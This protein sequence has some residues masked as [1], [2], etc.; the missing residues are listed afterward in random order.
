MPLSDD[1]AIT[2]ADL[3]LAYARNGN[4]QAFRKLVERHVGLVTGVV[5]RQVGDAGA[6]EEAVQNVFSILA[7]KAGSA[8]ARPTLAGWLCRTAL[9]ESRRAQRRAA[10]SIR[11]LH[12][13]M[14]HSHSLTP[15]TPDPRWS[16]ALPFLDQA[17]AELSAADRDLLLL[18]FHER[19]SFQLIGDTLGKS[20]DASQKQSERALEKLGNL[21][22][23][24][25]ITLGVV[26]LAA[27]LGATLSAKPS[28]AQFNP[29][30]LATQAVSNAPS[31]GRLTLIHHTLETMNHPKTTT[32]IATLLLAV[33][34]L[35]LL[36]RE[37][38]S[39][40]E[41]LAAA[42]GRSPSLPSH[43]P[44]TTAGSRAGVSAPGL[45]SGLMQDTIAPIDWTQL[46]SDKDPVRRSNQFHHFLAT[47]TPD[48]ARNAS[49]I[50]TDLR[51]RE[52]LTADEWKLFLRAWAGVDGNTAMAYVSSLPENSVT[53]SGGERESALAGW[54]GQDATAAQAWISQEL[55]AKQTPPG[56][57]HPYVMEELINAVS[58][59]MRLNNPAAARNFLIAQAVAGN[60]NPARAAHWAVGD[61]N[62]DPPGTAASLIATLPSDGTHDEIRKALLGATLANRRT[63]ESIA[64]AVQYQEFLEPDS[65][66]SVSSY[67]SNTGGTEAMTWLDSLDKV[68]PD[69]KG[70]ARA[71][72][73][74]NWASTDPDAAGAWLSQTNRRADPAYAETAAAYAEAVVGYDPTAAIAWAKT[75][76]EAKAQH[77]TL[78]AMARSSQGRND[79]EAVALLMAQGLTEEEIKQSQVLQLGDDRIT[80]ASGF[81]KGLTLH[82]KGV[83]SY[84]NAV[85]RHVVIS[86]SI[87]EAPV[88][89]TRRPLPLPPQP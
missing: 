69:K 11:R 81:N 58:S 79:T 41:T 68:A 7:R 13:L 59:G 67:V 17:M 60:V 43:Q 61:I 78:I 2:D 36:W 88:G 28:S 51:N 4:Q 15:D 20:A 76:P 18:R 56:G 73:I 54:A 38:S 21:L 31:I 70:P 77:A 50:L 8:R 72:V 37:N 16:E 89:S 27:G 75:L 86:D 48:A 44:G 40:R 24:K 71:Q 22:R 32:F 5:R 53:R 57:P 74:T 45:A 39:L 63:D 65:L 84:P 85:N 35:G 26:A 66:K 1:P 19:K 33:L 52:K 62:D 42:N 29:S 9:F 3:L 12:E 47:L 87:N 46:T 6:A 25:G 80:F 49:A 64:L 34:P 30:Q 82:L 14:N 83:N 10:Q 23:R 55:V